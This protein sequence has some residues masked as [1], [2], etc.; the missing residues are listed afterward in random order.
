MR[1]IEVRDRE[2]VMPAIGM[3]DSEMSYRRG[4]QHGAAKTFR[5]VERFLDPAARE[6]LRA[7]IEQDVYGWRVKG[8]LGYPPIW[9]LSNL[10]R[11]K[12]KLEHLRW[13]MT[14]PKFS[15]MDQWQSEPKTGLWSYA[16]GFRCRWHPALP[17][18]EDRL[19]AA[20]A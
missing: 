5:A 16:R 9:R 12:V 3:D 6:V 2:K 19:L 10:K 18:R 15:D 17:E 13:V 1:W 8:M 11:S 7:W 20:W 14:A 4:Y